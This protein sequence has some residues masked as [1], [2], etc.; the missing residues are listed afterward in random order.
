MRLITKIR[1]CNKNFIDKKDQAY[2]LILELD[3]KKQID[4]QSCSSKY[5]YKELVTLSSELPPAILKH[6]QLFPEIIN[7]KANN[8]FLIPRVCTNN[9]FLKDLQYQI[10]HKYL[11]TNHLLYK[12]GKVSSMS[13]SFCNIHTENIYHLFYECTTVKGLWIFV[14]NMIENVTSRQVNLSCQQ[15]I[16]GYNF[17]KDDCTKYK[18]I[19][20]VILYVK[21]YIWN[22]RKYTE[23]PT[24]TGI[25]R[26]FGKCKVFDSTLGEFYDFINS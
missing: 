16:F 17:D 12:M 19:N 1:N 9:N 5:L 11:P 18:D 26:W 21:G 25:V 7:I 4:I 24:L 20:N 15:A 10:I 23:Q 3:S 22:C 6:S 13:C 14:Q 8:I 2:K